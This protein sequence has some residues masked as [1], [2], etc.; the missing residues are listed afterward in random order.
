M[1]PGSGSSSASSAPASRTNDVASLRARAASSARRAAAVTSALTTAATTRNTTSASTF[2]PSLIVHVWIGGVRYQLTSRN[3]AT[4]AMPATDA[5]P[6]AATTTTSSRY[7]NRS[8][9]SATLPR[10]LG[11]HEREQ[12]QPDQSEQRG[13]G[14][15]LGAIHRARTS[16]AR[17][18]GWPARPRSRVEMMC[19]SMSPDARTTRLITEPCRSEPQRERR[20]EPM[21]NC[22]ARSARAKSTS[23]SDGV[24]ADDLVIRAAEVF[25][26]HAVPFEHAG[27]RARRAL[28]RRARAHRADRPWRASRYAKPGARGARPRARPSARPPPV[29]ASPTPSVMPWSSM[30]R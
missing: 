26:E 1:I 6:T 29:R 30:Y 8:L 11:E 5:P 25:E 14:L 4:A 27:R 23:A 19:T 28:R 13:R 9:P 20:L 10:C 15:A 24:G 7:S 12:G 16:A 17:A 22:V 18:T 2:W 3:A 21:T